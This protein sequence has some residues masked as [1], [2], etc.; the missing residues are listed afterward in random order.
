MADPALDVN[1][2]GAQ[3]DQ[4]KLARANALLTKPG[5]LAEKLQPGSIAAHQ[6]LVAQHDSTIAG[7]QAQ[8]EQ[9]LGSPGAATG[10]VL[11]ATGV[12][13]RP[14]APGVQT[15]LGVA[16]VAPLP[17]ATPAVAVAAPAPQAVA[18]V[19]ADP[20]Y[21]PPAGTTIPASG[22]IAGAA[23]LGVAGATA[24]GPVPL[25]TFRA[26]AADSSFAA[27]DRATLGLA[28]IRHTQGTAIAE[29]AQGLKAL[30][31]GAEVAKHI[32]EANNLGVRGAIAQEMLKRDPNN[33]GGAAG[34]TMGRTQAEHTTVLPSM[35]GN[36]VIQ[37]TGKGVPTITTPKRMVSSQIRPGSDGKFY[38]MSA[39]GQTAVR[40]ATATERAAA[41][42]KK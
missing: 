30:Q 9:G 18:P 28:S 31:I 4:A 33:L 19:A 10:G 23:G 32:A 12:Q 1:A 40:E 22:T 15:Q 39:D 34:A 41:A 5:V 29:K 37:V 20:A 26:N 42:A 16:P 38:V 3:L 27:A 17:V 25:S 2:I 21:V 13:P 11:T 24:S 6:A 14:A 7:L 8:Y 35:T 36:D